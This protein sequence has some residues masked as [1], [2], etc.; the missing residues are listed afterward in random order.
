MA[1]KKRVKALTPE[2]LKE[3]NKKEYTP[4][5]LHSE[6]LF[7]ANLYPVSD[8]F[9]KQ[10]TLIFLLDIADFTT[11]R[12]VERIHSWNQKYA[13]LPWQG[14]FVMQQ[15]YAFLK[16]TKFFDR[17]KNQVI[18]LDPFNELFERFGS[19]KNRSP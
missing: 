8:S 17:F 15:K 18:F 16:E 10:I 5:W 3:K 9:T 14:V 13:K 19:N 4:F 6:V 12:L 1:L 11:E 2:E 7:G